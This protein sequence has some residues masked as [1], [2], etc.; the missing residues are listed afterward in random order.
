MALVKGTGA[1]V[2]PVYMGTRTVRSLDRYLRARAHERWAHLEAL[3]ITQRGALIPD[4]ARGRIRLR[5]EAESQQVHCSLVQCHGAT[6]RL[7]LGRSLDQ[8]A[9]HANDLPEDGQRAVEQVE[10]G[11]ARPDGLAAA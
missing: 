1:K 4:G 5:G 11:P 9:C 6:A 2:R 10:V 7:G 3:F 8:R